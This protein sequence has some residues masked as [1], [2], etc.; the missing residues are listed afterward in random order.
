MEQRD[1]LKDQIEQLGRVLGKIFANFF[2]LKAEGKIVLGMEITQQNLKS[3]LDLDID[4]M[5]GLT[6]ENLNDYLI[7][8]RLTPKHV[9]DLSDYLIECGSYYLQSDKNQAKTTLLTAMEL[10]KISND[11]SIMYSFDRKQKEEK[12]KDLMKI[13]DL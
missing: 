11:H 10:L 4:K 6:K 2:G 13:N 5:L 1:L 9:D 12:I 8:K 3:E 7:N